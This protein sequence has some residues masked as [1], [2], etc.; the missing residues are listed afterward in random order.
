MPLLILNVTFTQICTVPS[1]EIFPV[2]T[3]FD[4]EV[5]KKLL[6]WRS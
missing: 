3:R 1:V 5:K 2:I 6:V 4:Y